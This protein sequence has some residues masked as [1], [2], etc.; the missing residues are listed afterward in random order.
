MDDANHRM[1]LD[2][3]RRDAN[4]YFLFLLVFILLFVIAAS[5]TFQI[6]IWPLEK[7]TEPI[8]VELG[9][10]VS[11][12][13]ATYFDGASFSLAY[14]K[15]DPHEV[16]RNKVGLYNVYA[17]H[18]ME[19]YT[20]R[21]IVRDTESPMITVPKHPVYLARDREYKVADIIETV[22]DQSGKT[23]LYAAVG[24][25]TSSRVT[26]DTNGKHTQLRTA[27]APHIAGEARYPEHRQSQAVKA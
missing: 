15:I 26:F 11:T 14:V 2:E 5:V 21:V 1:P 12:D 27:Q 4:T 16:R 20:F 3:R 7:R 23:K 24:D 6:F 13:P 19:T 18:G 10:T 25:K 17:K 8:Y 9:T 22:Y